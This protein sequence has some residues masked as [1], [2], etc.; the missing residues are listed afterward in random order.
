MNTLRPLA[1]GFCS[2]AAKER[3]RFV[4]AVHGGAG[5]IKETV[6]SIGEQPYRQK[7]NEALEAGHSILTVGGTS[8]DAVEAA[9]KV[10][11]DS[12]LFNA[13]RGSVFAADGT[14]EME[15]SIV[16][17]HTRRAG[18]VYGLRTTRHPVSAARVVMERSPHVMLGPASERWL[19]AAGLEQQDASWFGTDVRRRQ[20]A[21]AKRREAAGGAAM[22]LDHESLEDEGARKGTVGAVALDMH[23][24][25]AAATSTGGMTNKWAGRVGDSPIIGAGTHACT[26]CAV[27]CTGRGEQFL[28]HSVAAAVGT[29]V[30]SGVPLPTACERLI[31]HTLSPDDGGLVAIDSRGTLSMPFSTTGMFRG[32]A[33]HTQQPTVAI[34]NDEDDQSHQTQRGQKQQ[35]TSTEWQLQQP[36]AAALAIG[37]A[38]GLVMGLQLAHVRT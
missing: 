37:V 32:W 4:L 2:A 8:L 14:H 21:Q 26:A 16:Q 20:L 36:V 1:R 35:R 29:L 12:E 19:G 30:A 34:W 27:S 31:H 18:A 23:G 24:D 11:E 5:V 13:G 25:L 17:G 3:G 9:V 28:R 38:C 10:L 33:S 15:A 6:A 22:S 7:L